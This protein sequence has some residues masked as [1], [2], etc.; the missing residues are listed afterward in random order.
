MTRRRYEAFE[1]RLTAAEGVYRLE[2]TAS[3]Q[4][5]QPSPTVVDIPAGEVAFP[6]SGDDLVALG[7][8]LW[9]WLFPP[10]AE[11]LYR[12][13]LAALPSSAG[14][15]LRLRIDPPELAALPWELAYDPVR[16]AFPAL[17][18]RTPVVRYVALPFR[19]LSLA[20]LSPL[21][22]LFVASAPG[23]QVPLEAAAEK[24]RLLEA[25][26]DLRQEGHVVVDALKGRATVE[27][28]QDALRGGY[29]AL[30][31]SGHGH[32]G[33]LA[34]ERADGTAHWVGAEGLAVLLGDSGVALALLNAC[35][36]GARQGG[37]FAGVAPALVRA[38]LPAVVA[39]QAPLPDEGA[40][41]FG[42]NFY[43]ALADGLPVDAAVAEGR[44]A[45]SLAAGVGQP[46]WAMPVLYLRAPDGVLWDFGAG[47]ETR[48]AAARPAETGDVYGKVTVTGGVVGA[49]G[50]RGHRIEQRIVYGDKVMGDKVMGDKIGLA[51]GVDAPGAAGSPSSL[52]RQLAEAEADLELIR[53][54]QA[55][56]VLREDV[57]PQLIEGER[58][59][60]AR[61][62]ELKDELGK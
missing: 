36:T 19:P 40:V 62:A 29:R 58:R 1:L 60:L 26:T 32:A 49:V 50:G 6:E 20:G 51:G 46:D 42:R 54:R 25:L 53:G 43:A 4:G 23:D 38:G 15:R 2:V 5:E 47:Q 28:M 8:R 18:A 14:L 31:F 45:V 7:R 44:K 59:L 11:A 37:P 9:G 52:R 57:P 55:R 33:A 21:R 56:Y 17:S 39:M 3:P 24:A 22:I 16:G 35:R 41:R 34:L 13:A 10:P 12:A 48:E 61:I 27:A 30:H